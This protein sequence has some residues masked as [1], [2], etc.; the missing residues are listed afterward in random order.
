VTVDNIPV[1]K[2]E[3]DG[4]F[5]Y[6]FKRSR[7][8]TSPIIISAV[9][10]A[11]N[12]A[13]YSFDTL[14]NSRGGKLVSTM[15]ASAA[16]FGRNHAILIAEKDYTDPGFKSLKYPVK[17]ANNL[18]QVLLQRYTF[19][20]EDIDTLYNR[21]R[22]DILE[23]VMARCKSLGPDDN[24]L[25]FYAGHGDTTMDKFNNVDG[26]LIPTSAQKGKISYFITSEEIKKALKNSNARHILFLLDA[27]YSGAF[28][29]G[30]EVTDIQTTDMEKQ[31]ESP[32]RK[33]MT[34]GNIE[35]VPDNSFFIYYLTEFLRNN[36]K[37]FLSTKD[38]WN[39]VDNGIREHKKNP[40]GQQYYSPQYSAI[41]G[42][43]DKGGT[44]IFVLRKTD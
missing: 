19:E 8:N 30:D 25:V 32:S 11:N 44:Y 38:L 39:Y 40:D 42:V 28:T 17:D 33:V 24:L 10:S 4:F 9:D 13:T 20:P 22:E 3:E 37:Q 5:R 21:S 1:T 18:R 15:P 23:T 7:S 31:W 27:C 29:R 36:K 35:A 2:L 43:G 26:Y 16:K 41:T 12:I 34:S 14:S 6:K